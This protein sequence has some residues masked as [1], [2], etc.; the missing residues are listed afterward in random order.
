[1]ILGFPFET[2]ILETERDLL[3]KQIIDFFIE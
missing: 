3:M 2:V 1:V